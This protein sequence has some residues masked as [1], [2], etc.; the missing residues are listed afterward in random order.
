MMFSPPKTGTTTST[1]TSVNP[2]ATPSTTPKKSLRLRSTL[3]MA[4]LIALIASVI[5]AAPANA[6]VVTITKKCTT[7]LNGVTQ[8][9]YNVDSMFVTRSYASGKWTYKVTRSPNRTVTRTL[10]SGGTR[11]VE[12]HIDVIQMYATG[13]TGKT[14]NWPGNTTYF[15][16]SYGGMDFFMKA[17]VTDSP[18]YEI[19]PTCRI[20]F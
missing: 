1:E 3:V 20:T 12:H 19:F 8:P 5:M 14:V 2:A 11:Y 4:A 7:T 9:S 10:S 16:S 18:N 13:Y 15:Y 17:H 6:A